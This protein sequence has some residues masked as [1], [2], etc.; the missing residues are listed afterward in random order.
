MAR[1]LNRI[2][3]FGFLDMENDH[4]AVLSFPVIP[5][6]DSTQMCDGSSAI[7]ALVISI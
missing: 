6:T 3:N 4:L 7:A 2:T 5:Q 1:T